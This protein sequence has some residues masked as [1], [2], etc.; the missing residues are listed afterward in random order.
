VLSPEVANKK[1][2]ITSVCAVLGGFMGRGGIK[3]LPITTKDARNE[4]LTYSTTYPKPYGCCVTEM[5]E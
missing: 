1:R 5:Y 4:L 3:I 2:P